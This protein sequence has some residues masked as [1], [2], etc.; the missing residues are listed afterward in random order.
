MQFCKF[1]NKT[2]PIEAFGLKKTGE[3]NVTCK[4]CVDRRKRRNALLSE[5][6]IK[7]QNAGVLP[8]MECEICEAPLTSK[9]AHR[10]HDHKTGLNRGLLC[11]HCNLGLGHFRDSVDLLSAAIKYLN[12]PRPNATKYMNNHQYSKY[13]RQS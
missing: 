10:D 9:S 6:V 11:A 7:A 5:E 1:C 2:Q 3:R 8:K 13:K 4:S 12:T